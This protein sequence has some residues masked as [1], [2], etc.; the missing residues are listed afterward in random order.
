MLAVAAQGKRRD[1]VQDV[2]PVQRLAGSGAGGSRLDW[3][4]SSSAD[5]SQIRGSLTQ[6]RSR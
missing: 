2:L 5:C 4:N 3:T 1:V 6:W